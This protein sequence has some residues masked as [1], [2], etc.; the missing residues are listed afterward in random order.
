MTNKAA[1]I[2]LYKQ[3]N[4]ILKIVVEKLKNI[5]LS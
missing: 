3:N 1:I 4:D 5:R 2:V